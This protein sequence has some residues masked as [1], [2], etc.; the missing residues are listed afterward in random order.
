MA[1]AWL[2][3]I[4]AVVTEVA[5]T[6]SM[7]ASGK[8]DGILMYVLMCLFI[9]TSYWFLSFALKR[10]AVGVAIAIW[11]GLGVFLISTISVLFLDQPLN[12]QKT[13]GLILA[14]TGIIL[15]N[16]GEEKEGQH[17]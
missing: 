8:S 9:G 7:N 2:F 5:G 11:E 17:D 15:L 3:L 12:L 16:F 6:L 4:L 10:I 13:I 14:V 1:Y